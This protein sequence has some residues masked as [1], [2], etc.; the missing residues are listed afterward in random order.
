VIHSPT[1][2]LTE[3]Q[4][5]ALAHLPPNVAESL[6][7]FCERLIARFGD[8]LR[9]IIL[10]GS[11]ARGDW[12]A[13][14]DVDVM[15]VM[16]WE[17]EQL[18]DG[19][20]RRPNDPRRVEIGDAAYRAMLECDH[21][22]HAF[23]IGATHFR[24]GRA[25]IRAARR[26]GIELYHHPA[27][28]AFVREERK[29]RRVMK[30]STPAY[31]VDPDDVGDIQRWLGQA[32]KELEVARLLFGGGFYS[33]LFS[34]V[35]YAMFYAAKAALLTEDIEVKS[36]AGAIAEFGRVFVTTGRF[37][38]ELSGLLSR[39]FTQRIDSDY[40]LDFRPGREE[41]EQAIHDAEAFIARAR[42]LVDE[43]LTKRGAP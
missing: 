6:S 13:E 4:H 14:S 25:A 28:P 22:V 20:Y 36:H 29:R 21:F 23:D 15:V 19:A 12:H 2:D 16:A 30:E 8:D 39:R 27:L 1:L 37:P 43:E 40:T 26:E 31:S 24:E 11:F 5:R 7:C 42:E 10:Y 41:A 38:G 35:Y 32:Q 3:T 18:P 34:N 17:D 9:R 33:D